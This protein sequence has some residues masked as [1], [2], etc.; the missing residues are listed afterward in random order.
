MCFR[1][2]FALALA[3]PLLAVETKPVVG[4]VQPEIRL[5]DGTVF[6]KAKIIEY[7][8]AK[9]TATIADPNRIRTVPLKSLP[10]P[11]RKQL[12]AE[13]GVKPDEPHRRSDR[14]YPPAPPP[15]DKVILPTAP[16]TTGA[17]P[18][19]VDQLTRQAT[20][21]APG[22]LKLYLQKAYDRVSSLTCKVRE[23][24]QVPGW[25]K[26]RVRG[27]ASFSQWDASQRD[28]VWR[29]E[30]FEVVFDIV[31]GGSLRVDTV[32]F[33]GFAHSVDEG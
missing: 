14:S 10:E 9:D 23:A 25:Q 21:E 5:T 7:S 28:Y 8:L 12:L 31:D 4:T 13:A 17:P 3:G 29:S 18:T 30:K 32:A 2:I 6:T 19:T 33:G 15:P 16:P 1:L 22:E 20:T 26:I 24:A 27:S 11:L